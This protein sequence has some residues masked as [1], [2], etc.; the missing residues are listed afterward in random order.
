MKTTVTPLLLTFLLIVT[1]CGTSSNNESE[2]GKVSYELTQLEDKV[3]MLDDETSV[4]GIQAQY[5]VVDAVGYYTFLNRP[6]RHIY[7]YN[8][9]TEEI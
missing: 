3:F 6:N 2:A 4:D 5:V 9:K 8:Y 1:A 7:F